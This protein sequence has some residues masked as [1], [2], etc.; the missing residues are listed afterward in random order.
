MNVRIAQWKPLQL[1]VDGV[2]PFRNGPET[3]SLSAEPTDE[4]PA[5]PPS[6]LYMLVAENGY[7]KTTLLECIYALYGLMAD[8]AVGCFAVPGDE[9]RAQLDIQAEWTA[10]GQT[11][12]GVVSIWT[13]TETPLVAWSHDALEKA[14]A[15][16]HWGRLGLQ[17][18]HDGV[19]LAKDTNVFGRS[20]YQTITRSRG[21]APATLFGADQ[22]MP[23]VLCFAA[24][25]AMN[26]PEQT[27][28][29][30]RPNGLAYQPAH[31]FEADGPQWRTSIDSLLV[32]LE[33][34]DDGRLKELLGF[35]NTRVFEGNRPKAIRRPRRDELATYVSTATGDHPLRMLSHGERAM[36]Q[37][38]VRIACSM[39]RNTVVLIDGM[40]RHLHPT[41]TFRLLAG[42]KDMLRKT[43]GLAI[44]FTTHNREL[45][46]LFD[47]RRKEEGIAKGGHVI[48]E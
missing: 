31:R 35:V 47:H 15:S 33:W 46:R 29:V 40:E 44:V 42:L 26:E 38:Y 23:S 32:W 39:T 20:V 19:S 12:T 14:E 34:L 6:N 45:I 3:F 10:D 21:Q 8:P 7:G 4:N 25:R 27:R 41:R 37:L 18:T 24:D 48:T 1:T 43:P 5:A 16:S 22:E 11:Q 13:G 2:G 9:G 17:M 36:L 30:E 28:R